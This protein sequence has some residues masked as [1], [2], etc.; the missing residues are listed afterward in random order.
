MTRLLAMRKKLMINAAAVS[1]R[2]VPL[3]RPA[4]RSGSSSCDPRTRGITAT[5]VSKPDSPSASFGKTSSATPIMTSGLEYC[6]VSA[7]SQWTT[8]SGRARRCRV[9]VTTMIRLSAR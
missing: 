8:V 3:I 7:F 6:A 5:P 2:L 9:D 1:R 4:G